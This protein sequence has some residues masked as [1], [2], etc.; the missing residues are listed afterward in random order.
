MSQKCLKIRQNLGTCQS[1]E[2]PAIHVSD[3]MNDW[4]QSLL[5]GTTEERDGQEILVLKHYNEVM[6]G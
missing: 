2:I 1:H 5:V 6:L 3:L 4:D